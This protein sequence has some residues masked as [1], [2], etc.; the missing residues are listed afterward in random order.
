MK[1]STIFCKTEKEGRRFFATRMSRQDATKSEA[2]LERT[3]RKRR[4]KKKRDEE[5]RKQSVKKRA[6]ERK[7]HFDENI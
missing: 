2:N 1:K 6:K 7:Y 4:K 5:L 3:K